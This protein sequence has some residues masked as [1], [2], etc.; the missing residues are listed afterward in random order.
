MPKSQGKLEKLLNETP[1]AYYWIGF[2]AADG[3]FSG[4]NGNRL[5]VKVSLKDEDHLRRLAAYLETKNLV[6]TPN[7]TITLTLSDRFAAPL[8]RSKFGLV[9]NKTY[10]PPGNLDFYLD[11][12]KDLFLAF[13]IGFIDGDGT[14]TKLKDRRWPSIVI[15]CHFSWLSFF[16]TFAAR[17]GTLF[18]CTL[19]APHLQHSKRDQLTWN[20]G[21]SVV[22]KGLKEFSATLPVI[23]RKWDR[24]DQ[25]AVVRHRVSDIKGLSFDKMTNRWFVRLKVLGRRYRGGSFETLKEAIEALEAKRKALGVLDV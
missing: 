10:N 8:I 1:E 6:L 22:V 23:S 9:R 12:Q 5:Q 17:L 7:N 3:C 11:L 25:T 13:L 21:R 19:G 16:L 14:I 2:I 18:S 24:I 15:G 20:I 4:K